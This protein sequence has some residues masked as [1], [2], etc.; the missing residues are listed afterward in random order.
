[1]GSVSAAHRPLAIMPS[2]DQVPVKSPHSTMHWHMWVVLIAGSAGS[3]LRAVRPPNLHIAP[4][5]GAIFS[6]RKCD[7]FFVAANAFTQLRSCVGWTPKSCAACIYD[8]PRSLISRTASSLNSR[9]NFRL[10]MTH[11][12]LHQNT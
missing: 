7:G 5:L 10:S 11:L 1:M 3:A 2:A 4:D 8:T 6:R 12:R 9:V